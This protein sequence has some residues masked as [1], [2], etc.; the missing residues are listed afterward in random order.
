M[1]E[2]VASIGDFDTPLRRATV[3]SSNALKVDG[4]AVTQPVS[5]TVTA[6]TPAA[7]TNAV[8]VT[9]SAVVSAT[10]K[11]YR[12]F[13]IRET[14]GAPAVVSIY[15]NASTNSGTIIEQISL[16]ANESAREFYGDGGVTTVNGIYFSVV[17]GTV[18]GSV[19]TS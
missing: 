9:V 4:S 7:S 11:G 3:T 17:S 16:L 13:S 5:G 1:A 2:L 8:A 10:P 14:A 15:D 18:A 6:S 19:R 12:G